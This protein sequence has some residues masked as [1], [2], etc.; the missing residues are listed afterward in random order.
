MPNNYIYYFICKV[1]FGP[2][3]NWNYWVGTTYDLYCGPPTGG[4]QDVLELSSSHMKWVWQKWMPF[5]L[6]FYAHWAV[7]HWDKQSTKTTA[8]LVKPPSPSFPNFNGRNGYRRVYIYICRHTYVR[9]NKKMQ[10]RNMRVNILFHGSSIDHTLHLVEWDHGTKWQNLCKNS[11]GIFTWE[12]VSKN[13][14]EGN[15]SR[16]F[17]VDLPAPATPKRIFFLPTMVAQKTQLFPW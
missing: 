5:G 12:K 6:V 11:M 4:D 2:C 16:T 1:W 17:L 15:G 13:K 9:E 14:R 7:N 8:R 3:P 10:D